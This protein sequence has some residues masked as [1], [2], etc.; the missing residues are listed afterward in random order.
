MYV[1]RKLLFSLV[2]GFF[3]LNEELV[4]ANHTLCRDCHEHYPMPPGTPV[5][6][7]SFGV[8]TGKF[9]YAFVDGIGRLYIPPDAYDIAIS[10]VIH[11]K[12]FYID[13]ETGDYAIYNRAHQTSDDMETTKT[14]A[15]TTTTTTTTTTV[16][17]DVTKL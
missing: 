5:K 16:S 1:F 13:T 11:D 6:L 2:I 3:L 17:G 10:A 4:G 12:P 7:S 14:R 8:F 9:G 15:T